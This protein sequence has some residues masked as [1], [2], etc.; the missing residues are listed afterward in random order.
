[1]LL[2]AAFTSLN[3]EATVIEE[4]AAKPRLLPACEI[5]F[6]RVNSSGG[7]KGLFTRRF[8]LL[9]FRLGRG[10]PVT[11]SH[12]DFQF[13][14]RGSSRHPDFELFKA[15]LIGWDTPFKAHDVL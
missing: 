15:F 1:M 12:H 10:Q 4:T 2:A 6:R 11:R 9:L 5:K 14:A 8:S 3:N 13:G 7:V